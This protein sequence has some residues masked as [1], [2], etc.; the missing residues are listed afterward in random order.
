MRVLH[1][2]SGNLYGGIETLIS[3]LAR[4]RDV[5]PEMEPT[6]ALCFEGRSSQELRQSGATVHLLGEAR[7]SRPW[8]IWRVRRAFAS[9]LRG[10]RP[11]VVVCHSSWNYAIFAPV[12]RRLGIPVAYWAHG[13]SPGKHWLERW[14]SWTR[15]DLVIA[16]SQWTR[17]NFRLFPG[18]PIEVVLCPV[19]DSASNNREDDRCGVRAE[20]GTRADA[21]V[22]VQV[23]RLEAWK[24]HVLLLDALALLRAVSDWEC[25]IVGGPQRPDEERYLTDLKSKAERDGIG[26]RV[27]FLGQRTDVPR[28]LTAADIHCQPNLE[29]EPFGITFIEALYCGLPVVATALG[30]PKEIVDETCG[31]TVEPGNV[32]ALAEFLRRLILLPEL[33]HKLGSGGPAR[34]R[35]LSDPS[36]QLRLLAAT[37]RGVCRQSESR[38]PEIAGKI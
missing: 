2:N 23:S 8:T 5:C 33:R 11:D 10:S 6:F 4:F 16:N 38:P 7:V 18:T 22:I 31:V 1:V 26:E 15:P 13:P 29:P 19:A 28:V 37:L 30:G 3:T 36:T 14:A 17:D 9:V 27:R 35:L 12:A 32:A 24:G 20:I 34:A 25:W 21:V